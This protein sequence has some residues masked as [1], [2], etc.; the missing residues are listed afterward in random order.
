MLDSRQREGIMHASSGMAK[1]KSLARIIKSQRAP[2]WPVGPSSSLPS[3]D[4]TDKLVD[5]YLR[6]AEK[7]YRVLHIPTFRRD[8]EAIW[9]ASSEPDP[10]FLVQL[11]LVLA[12]GAAVYDEK[13]SL[14]TLAIHWVY[15]GQA[16][17]ADP[18]FKPRLLNVQSLQSNILLFLARESTGVGEESNWIHAGAL[19]R[20]AMCMGL[21]RDPASLPT[22]SN[23]ASEMRRRVW[24]TIL[25]IAL[26][27]SITSGGPPLISLS[28]FD[29]KPPGNFDDDQL[30]V[31]NPTPKPEGA[32]TNISVAIALRKTFPVRLAI[33][34]FLNDLGSNGTY[35]ETLRL[36]EQF[37][38]SFK[39]LR[40]ALQSHDSSIRTLVP[41]FE[42]RAIEVIMY[43]YLIAL[44][45][46]FFSP[47]LRGTCYAFSRKVAVET[48]VKIWCAVFPSSS[49]MATQPRSDVASL[50]QDD[51]TRLSINGSG[52]FRIITIQAFLTVAGELKAQLDERG[53]SPVPLRVSTKNWLMSYLS[54]SVIQPSTIYNEK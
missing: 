19:I 24:N 14:R 40:R 45:L 9:A 50:E 48:S 17:L 26:Q 23:F 27:P 11:K 44:H 22:R 25:E 5:C 20:V 15:E 52:F 32:Y 21:H 29:T 47:S 43:R 16:W 30:I 35:E 31:D 13:F 54:R 1:C 28:D 8:Y 46:P 49:I 36:D 18:D 41:K 10:A 12:I 42:I 6:T 2:P 39:I 53:L 3:K 38:A 51:L 7:V 37:R 33:V 34:K 4:V